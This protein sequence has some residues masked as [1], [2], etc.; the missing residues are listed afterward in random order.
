ML[1]LHHTAL[2]D[3][4]V[5]DTPLDEGDAA[6]LHLGTKMYFSLNPTGAQIWNYL[7]DGLSLEDVSRRLHDQYEVDIEDARRSVAQLVEGLV[8]HNL[9][10]LGGDAGE[11]LRD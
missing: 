3:P 9:V 8:Q 4:E 5:V 11:P 2:P 7:K 6:L 1:S 10:S